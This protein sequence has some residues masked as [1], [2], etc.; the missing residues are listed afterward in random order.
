MRA[1]VRLLGQD[2][3]RGADAH[4]GAGLAPHSVRSEADLVAAGLL[5][6]LDRRNRQ[7]ISS[8]TKP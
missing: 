2:E 1:G 4:H 3:E 8:P 6:L 5:I 7:T